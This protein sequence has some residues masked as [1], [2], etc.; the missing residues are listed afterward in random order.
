MRRTP[1]ILASLALAAMIAGPVAAAKP[2]REAVGFGTITT[3][4]FDTNL[5]GWVPIDGTVDFAKATLTT[6]FDGAGNVTKQ[7]YTGPVFFHLHDAASG[8]S[9]DINV[10]GPAILDYAHDL[11]MIT[12]LQLSG[13]TVVTMG[14]YRFGTGYL[15]GTARDLCPT[16]GYL[17]YDPNEV[18]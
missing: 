5:N 8:I 18:P 17:S 15:Q 2:T 7:T 11:L 12:G 10:S 13:N 14:H 4:C 3:Y 9:V 1:A 6:F 16:F